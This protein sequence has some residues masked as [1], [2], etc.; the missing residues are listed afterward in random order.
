MV[1]LK[2]KTLFENSSVDFYQIA[3]V[4]TDVND[5]NQPSLW[6]L[7][8]FKEIKTRKQLVQMWFFSSEQEQ[9]DEIAE[10]MAL[11]PHISID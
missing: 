5:V 3:S 2:N 1:A 11:Y 4:R 6:V 7:Y 10:I 9:T 8:F